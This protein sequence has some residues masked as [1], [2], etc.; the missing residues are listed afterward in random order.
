[1]YLLGRY[2]TRD[3]LASLIGGYLF[4]FSSYELGEMPGHLNLDTIFVVPLVVLLANASVTLTASATFIPKKLPRNVD[5][6]R[7]MR[8]SRATPGSARLTSTSDRKS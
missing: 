5:G 1:M 4:G 6:D 2:L 3:T 8:T 7:A